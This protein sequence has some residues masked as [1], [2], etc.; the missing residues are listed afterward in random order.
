VAWPENWRDAVM[1][2]VRESL[3]VANKIIGA[4][5]IAPRPFEE[6]DSSQF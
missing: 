2:K 5:V 4:I 3:L 1:P 6:F